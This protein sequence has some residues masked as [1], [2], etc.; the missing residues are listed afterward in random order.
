MQEDID[1]SSA[2]FKKKRWRKRI[3]LE[4]KKEIIVMLK[5]I[6]LSNKEIAEELGVIEK[7]VYTLEKQLKDGKIDVDKVD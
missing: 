5:D 1:Y 6:R 7:V 4:H 2:A 3:S